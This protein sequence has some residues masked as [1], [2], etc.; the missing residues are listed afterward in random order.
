MAVI[1]QIQRRVQ[2]L[3]ARLQAEVLD[4]TEFLLQ[5]ASED[6]AREGST[7]S[8]SSVLRDMSDED[9]PAY[10]EADVKVPLE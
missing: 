2:R 4:V 6:E 1:D 7:L 5:R 8:V 3:P 10:T 9:E